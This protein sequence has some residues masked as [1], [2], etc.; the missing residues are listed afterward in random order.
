LHRIDFGADMRQECRT[1]PW[2]LEELH[3]VSVGPWKHLE[4]LPLWK[5]RRMAAYAAAAGLSAAAAGV[6]LALD[7]AIPTGFPF[8]LFFP[9]VIISAFLFG[10]GP[11]AFAGV[12][13]GVMARYLFMAPAGSLSLDGPNAVTMLFYAT[14]AV[15]DV[16]LVDLMQRAQS[17]AVAERERSGVLAARSE[18]LAARSERLAARTDLLFRELQHRVSNNLQMVGAV[19]TLQK[20]EVLDPAARSALEQAAGKLQLIGRIQRQLYDVSGGRV[21]LDVFLTELVDDLA[22]AGGK[23]GITYGVDAEAGISLKPDALIPLALIMAEGV[24]NALEHGFAERTSGHIAISVRAAAGLI[25]LTVTDDGEGLPLGFSSEGASSLGLRI[26]STLANQ[27][28]GTFEV[29]PSAAGGT[30]TR[31]VLPCT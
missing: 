3:L 4:R 8:V 28:E 12:L 19:L 16:A 7:P 14:V 6:R 17:V 30:I 2:R 23:P 20:R 29:V 10:C 18:R 1:G 22:M 24:A 13:C 9:A 26:A 27:L 25:E 5:E 15:V 21:A 11:G 31:L